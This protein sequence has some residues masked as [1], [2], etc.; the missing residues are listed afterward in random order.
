MAEPLGESLVNEPSEGGDEN[1][2]DLASFGYGIAEDRTG[3]GARH[4]L[5]R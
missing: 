5:L 4:T 1:Q 3:E 2:L